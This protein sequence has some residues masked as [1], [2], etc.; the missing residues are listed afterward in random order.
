LRVPIAIRR[1]Y[2]PSLWI[3]Q[4]F[5]LTN[6]NLHH[7]LLGLFVSCG[8][9]SSQNQQQ[10]SPPPSGQA[11]GVYEDSLSTGYSFE[12]IVLPNDN[13]YALYG[14]FSGDTF[15]I[16]GFV[17][18]SGAE[19]DANFSGSMTDFEYPG[20]PVGTA[21]LS[22]TFVAGASL[23]GSLTEGTLNETFTAT[24]PSTTQFNYNAAAQASSIAGSW[25]G[26]LLD[27][28]SAAVSIDGSGNVTG[29]SSLGCSFSGTAEPDSSGKNF[30]D[31]S[32]TFGG[33]PCVAAGQSA[34]GVGIVE[35]LSD[36]TLQVLAGLKN[37]GNT[38]ATVF[39][40]TPAP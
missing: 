11:Q 4:H 36:G 13:F 34:T 8:G 37:S 20:T 19:S 15:F 22:A 7:G 16:T 25:N 5:L 6:P 33:S 26:N 10:K 28:E 27:G 24:V 31:I 21:S 29:L 32:L 38:L 30:Y 40:G 23:K 2:K 14:T 9:N 39:V 17:F 3:P 1:F 18:G 12:T 35:T